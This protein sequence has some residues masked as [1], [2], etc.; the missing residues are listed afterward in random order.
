MKTMVI[1]RRA[2]SCLSAYFSHDQ[3]NIILATTIVG[4]VHQF[5]NRACGSLVGNLR[6]FGIIDFAVQAVT[7]KQEKIAFLQLHTEGVHILFFL[8]TDATSD[9]ILQ[10]MN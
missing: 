1:F 4:K 8:V 6:Q 9:H 7:A 10:M 3:S 2:M 5:W